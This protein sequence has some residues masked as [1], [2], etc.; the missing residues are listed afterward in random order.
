MLAWVKQVK[1]GAKVRGRQAAGLLLMLPCSKVTSSSSG[2]EQE[3]QVAA[4]WARTRD[5]RRGRT[6]RF[7]GLRL[8]SLR[9]RF[10]QGEGGREEERQEEL[11]V[12]LVHA[13]LEALQGGRLHVGDGQ[14]ELHD[15]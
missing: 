2:I 11:K 1:S 10:R 12:V 14:V 15:S 9:T 13:V 3:S 5:D 4:G 8:S 7:S 6:R